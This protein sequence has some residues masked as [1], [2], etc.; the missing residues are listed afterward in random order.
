M[1][2]RCLLAS[3]LCLAL[4][5]SGCA[6][7]ADPK[8]ESET[9]AVRPAATQAGGSPEELL[10]LSSVLEPYRA[11][12]ERV[13]PDAASMAYRIPQEI[14]AQAGKDLSL[15]G[16]TEDQG[17]LT[18]DLSVSNV[19]AYWVSGMNEAKATM[20]PEEMKE[21]V[22]GDGDMDTTL[23]GDWEHKGGGTYT[24]TVSYAFR[25]DFSSGSAALETA[26]NGAVSSRERFRFAVENGVFR[27]LDMT[28]TATGFDEDG[29]VTGQGWLIAFGVFERNSLQVVE[30]P[31]SEPLETGDE[32]LS[33][34]RVE[35]FLSR[36]GAVQVTVP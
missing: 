13:P 1:S 27:F 31:S 28:Y 18:C 2:K 14:F 24:R 8:K 21:D 20:T 32:G 11:V 3:V 15:Y 19:N 16:Y 4:F 10:G 35:D 36:P 6:P 5:A 23:M 33:A 12:L 9:A 34:L 17:L 30:Y 22:N 7:E 25:E 26:L 29:E